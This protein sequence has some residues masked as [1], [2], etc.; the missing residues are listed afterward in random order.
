MCRVL[1]DQSPNFDEIIWSFNLASDG[2][3]AASPLI[4]NCS[5][6][7]N[8]G[9]EVW[10]LAYRKWGTKRPSCLGALRALLCVILDVQIFV[11]E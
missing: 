5:A 7:W 1:G 6:L 2:F 8:S 9:P 10:S 3:Q 11:L 4:R